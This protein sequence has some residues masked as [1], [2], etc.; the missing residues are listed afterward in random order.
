MLAEAAGARLI[1]RVVAERP[2]KPRRK[3]T[4][5]V[6]GAVAAGSVASASAAIHAMAAPTTSAGPRHGL[7][8]RLAP[9]A[10]APP[11]DAPTTPARLVVHG[12]LC[13]LL[14]CLKVRSRQDVRRLRQGTTVLLR[15]TIRPFL[16]GRPPG[17]KL[18]PR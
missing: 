11:S 12:I 5:R 2:C 18:R 8:S 10:S 1:G 14:A 15:A 6:L 4:E 3:V 16:E 13:H 9:A 7:K 17:I